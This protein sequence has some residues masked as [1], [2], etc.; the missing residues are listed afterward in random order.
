MTT[1]L[2][3]VISQAGLA[4]RREA[5]QWIAEGRVTVNGRVINQMGTLVDPKSDVI[6][7][8]NRRLPPSEAKQY[9]IFNKPPG[10]VTTLE[11]ERGRPTVIQY[12]KK[13]ETRVFPVG[14]LDFNTQGAL[15]FTNDGELSRK[16]LD[17]KYRVPRVY[18]VK[19]RGT[20]NE[21]TLKRLR[22]GISLNHRPTEPLNVR[23]E[24]LSG[25]N[26]FLTMKLYEG[27]NR[28][29][30]RVCE[31]VGHPVIRLKR[32]YF[33]FLGLQGLALGK[34]RHLTSKE[35]ASLK[36]LVD[37]CVPH[38]KRRLKKVS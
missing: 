32:T 8:G 5:E 36:E 2:Q 34:Y 25:S 6:K 37:K 28:H 3:K 38:S 21:K 26:C 22:G 13:I 16:L 29:V 1:R 10:C 14:R 17:P 31:K 19:V 33:A 4:S 35:S 12:L 15:L 30:K 7:V 20:P 23:I 18:Q 9:I 27:K 11:D 24:R